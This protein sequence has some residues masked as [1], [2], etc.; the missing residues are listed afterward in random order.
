LAEKRSAKQSINKRGI[1]DWWM[2]IPSARFGELEETKHAGALGFKRGEYKTWTMSKASKR[3][4][5]EISRTIT[6]SCLSI[7]PVAT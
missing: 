7:S 1:C 6:N 5:N 3:E 2:K 4:Y